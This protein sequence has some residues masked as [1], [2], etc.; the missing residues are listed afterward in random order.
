VRSFIT[1]KNEIIP[2]VDIEL[3]E[4]EVADVTAVLRSGRLSM[5]PWTEEFE[6][7]FGQF[8]GIMHA[9]AVANCTAAIHLACEDLGLKVGGEVLCPSLTFVATA[10]AILYTGARPVFTANHLNAENAAILLTLARL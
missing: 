4:E 6:H 1:D 8:L 10:N 5:G 9:F 7:R 3:G 2:L